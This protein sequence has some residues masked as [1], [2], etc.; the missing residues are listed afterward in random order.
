MANLIMLTA[1]ICILMEFAVAVRLIKRKSVPMYSF[2][3]ALL[4][5]FSFYGVGDLQAVLFKLLFVYAVA[6]FVEVFVFSFAFG[7]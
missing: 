4:L 7:G 5:C 2:L 6:L 1:I 3:T